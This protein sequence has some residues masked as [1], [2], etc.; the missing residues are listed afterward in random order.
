MRISNY[1]HRSDHRDRRS[2]EQEYDQQFH[3]VLE[4]GLIISGKGQLVDVGCF[5][6][7]I[8]LIVELRKGMLEQLFP[9]D[10]LA[11]FLFWRL[12][13]PEVTHSSR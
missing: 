4:R 8:L 3:S 7:G 11:H 6:D 2:R 12:A 1:E 10:Q 5:D 13:G 9:R